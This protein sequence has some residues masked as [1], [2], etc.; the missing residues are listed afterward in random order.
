MS[1]K[2][3]FVREDGQRHIR[4]EYG[5]SIMCDEQYYPWVPAESY[6]W[7]L[8]AASPELY[9]ALEMIRDADE[10]C[11]RDGLPTI[12][13]AAR[14]TIEAALLKANPSVKDGGK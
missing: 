11:K 14:S 12:P 3:N 4:T 5:E 13:S 2:L 6:Y 9:E 7:L 8:F 1:E 10:D